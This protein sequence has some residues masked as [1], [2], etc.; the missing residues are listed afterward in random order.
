MAGLPAAF[1]KEV[2]AG[3]LKL[4]LWGWAIAGVGGVLLARKITGKASTSGNAANATDTTSATTTDTTANGGLVPIA[5]NGAV[6]VPG[7]ALSSTAV[8]IT[9]NDAWRTAAISALVSGGYDALLASD[10]V[11]KYLDGDPLTTQEQ[12]AITYA[13]TR[14]G[15]TPLPVAPSVAKPPATSTP[16]PAPK[17]PTPIVGSGPGRLGQQTTP[18]TPMPA[19]AKNHEPGEAFVDFANPPFGKG[20]W[21]LTNWGGVYAV[22]GAPFKGAPITSRI[23][24]SLGAAPNG[25]T[26]VSIEP[27]GTGYRV[28]D[29]RADTGDY[30][31]Q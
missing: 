17:T 29:N 20:T 25:Q 24:K 30:T 5:N 27:F 19:L 22:G 2:G 21:W 15:P 26:F 13:L 31:Y 16:S 8:L 1:T 11:E 12:G 28:H 14:I 3:P 23:A 9:D 10:A 6:S 18:N 4:P 7:G